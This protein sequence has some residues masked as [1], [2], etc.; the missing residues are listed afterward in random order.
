MQSRKVCQDTA[1]GC[2]TGS[3]A[4]EKRTVAVRA[5]SLPLATHW[6]LPLFPVFVFDFDF[7]ECKPSL[8]ALYYG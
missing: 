3:A 8:N 5:L 4:W 1:R 7:K 2:A 6:A